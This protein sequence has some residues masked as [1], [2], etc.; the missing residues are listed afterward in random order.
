MSRPRSGKCCYCKSA[1]PAG[2][3]QQD[4]GSNGVRFRHRHCHAKEMRRIGE[5]KRTG[6]PKP[7]K[8]RKF[9]SSLEQAKAWYAANKD[10][11]R[12]YDEKRRIENRQLYRDASKRF[13]Q[14]NPGRKNAD[15]NR[16]RTAIA[17]RKPTWIQGNELIAFYESAARVSKCL[18]IPHEIDH[19]IP[20]RGKA[21]SGL[22]VPGNLRVFPARLN[23]LK[24]NHFSMTW[25]GVR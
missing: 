23:N 12:A 13:R 2:M 11:K 3:T 4:R 21:V 17:H 10:R 1:D 7:R 18:Q 8:P 6:P 22:H 5:I 16:R 15:T 14:S 19:I 9:I 20:L 25:G 24:N